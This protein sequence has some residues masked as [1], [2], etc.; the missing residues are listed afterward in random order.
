MSEDVQAVADLLTQNAQNNPP[1]EIQKEEPEQEVSAE[2][3]REEVDTEEE[4][5]EDEEVTNVE[6]ITQLANELGVDP[7][8]VYGL[9]VP[10]PEGVE[11]KTLGEIKDEYTDFI[12]KK[13]QFETLAK[14][15]EQRIQSGSTLPQV[16]IPPEIESK[17]QETQKD[18]LSIEQAYNSIDWAEYEKQDPGSAALQKQK[19]QEAY[20]AATGNLQQ[21]HQQAQQ[22]Q[23]QAYQQYMQNE[24]QKVMQLIPEWNDP[25][26]SQRE[27]NEVKSL[28]GEYGFLPSEI[29]GIVDSRQVKLVVDLV[30]LKK[31]LKEA[32]P[33]KVKKQTKTLKPGTLQLRN[34]QK[35]KGL[36]NL[37][38]KAKG[39]RDTRVKV[40]AI[41]QLLMNRKR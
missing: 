6:T 30:R 2:E 7:A 27:T 12:H 41:S 14:E 26:T 17:M 19:F 4:T 15:Y 20:Q 35:E 9:K 5:Q 34:R 10:M 24:H 1:E 25:Q 40:D 37:I 18:V 36:A 16:A 23:Q 11:A 33:S 8:D 21:L 39:T 22:H 31:G 13:R 28:L 38:A 32:K 29:D 3:L